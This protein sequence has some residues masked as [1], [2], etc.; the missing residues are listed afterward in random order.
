VSFEG[1]SAGK[2]QPLKRYNPVTRTTPSAEK[3][4]THPINNTQERNGKR[5]FAT[6]EKKKIRRAR[7]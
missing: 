3:N 5:E 7:W 1:R 2:C 6:R 4:N